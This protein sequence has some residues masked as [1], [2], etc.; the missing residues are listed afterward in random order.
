[1]RPVL[2]QQVKGLSVTFEHVFKT[3]F[4]QGIPVYVIGGTVRDVLLGVP[5]NKI[6]DVDMAFGTSSAEMIQIANKEGWKVPFH[7]MN[8]LVQLGDQ[9]ADLHLEGKSINALNN[10]METL[11]NCPKSIG[12]DLHVEALYRD[13]TC[14]SLCYDPINEVIIDPTGNGVEDAINKVLRIPARLGTDQKTYFKWDQWLNGIF[15]S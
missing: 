11:A 7:S 9:M 8:G 15:H 2:K 10:D 1:M 6:K 4:D 5:V 14:N 12:N 13:F 3:L